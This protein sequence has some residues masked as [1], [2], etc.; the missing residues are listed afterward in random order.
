MYLCIY[1]Y[2]DIHLSLYVYIYIYIY[3]CIHSSFAGQASQHVGRLGDDRLR[4]QLGVRRPE[5]AGF[6]YIVS[7][8]AR[9]Y[10]YICIY[11]YIYI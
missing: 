1:I 8:Y 6:Y 5:F 3:I 7:C 10:V 4:E 11:I 9:L 2:I